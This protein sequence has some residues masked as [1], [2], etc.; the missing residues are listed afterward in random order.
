MPNVGKDMEKRALLSIVGG[1]VKWD[2][3]DGNLAVAQWLSK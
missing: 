3:L 2:L 1:R